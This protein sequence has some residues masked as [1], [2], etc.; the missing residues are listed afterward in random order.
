[1]TRSP[2]SRSGPSSGSSEKLNA[3]AAWR[4]ST[5][6]GVT[7]AVI[8]SGVDGYHPDLA[9]QVLPGNDFVDAATR[10]AARTRSGHGTTVA[11]LIAGRADDAAGV[12]GLAPDAKI[13]PVRVLDDDNRYDDAAVVAKGVR[14]AVDHGAEV[15]QPVPRRCRRAAPR[16]PTRIDYAFA[17]TSWSSPAPAT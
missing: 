9:G 7:V 16:S 8:D 11:G 10:R 2:P 4:T 15:G 13:L 17:K 5:G 12:V 3:A 6:A 1:M 14:W